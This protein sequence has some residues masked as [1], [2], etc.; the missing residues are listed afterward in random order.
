M[1]RQQE[2]RAREQRGDFIGIVSEHQP[3]RMTIRQML[4]MGSVNIGQV[5]AEQSH[6]E[7]ITDE[8][9]VRELV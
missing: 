3:Q 9:R 7:P 4:D 8:R 2:L 1:T 5:L 6:V